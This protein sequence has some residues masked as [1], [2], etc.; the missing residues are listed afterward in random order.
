MRLVIVNDVSVVLGGAT[1]VA[2]QCIEAGIAAGMDCSVLVGD[3]GEGVR[4]R[5][6][7]AKVTSLGERPLR[8][9]VRLRDVIDRNYNRRAYEALDNMLAEGDEETVVHVHGWSQILSPSIFHALARHRARVIVTAHDFF[10]NCPNGGY[11]NF[12]TGDVCNY[13]PMST[14]C[15]C[16]NCDKRNYMH[17]LWRVGRMLTQRSAGQTFWNRVEVILAHENMEPY[18][19][20]A[21]LKHFRTLRT[22]CKPLTAE[23]VRA[24]QNDRTLFLGRMTWEKGVRTLAEALNRTGRTATLIGQGPLL[25]EMQDALPNCYVPGWLEDSEVQRIAAEARFFL[26][27][28]RMP[29]P[30]G[31]V[32]AEAMMSGIPVIVSSNALIAEE[33]ASNGAGLVFESGNAASL[34][35]KMAMMDSVVTVRRLSEGAYEYGKR[36]A[37]DGYEWSRRLTDIYQRSK[38]SVVEEA[39]VGSVPEKVQL[40]H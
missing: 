36:I 7:G 8:D 21:G 15:V 2:M 18:L 11:L 9:G 17:K 33:V 19:R 31:L 35:E 20:S 39:E 4:A 34:A 29:E 5:F 3:D 30:Y 16:S 28:S 37:P 10:L 32:A 25:K 1:K 24:W 27:P 38:P 40:I 6:P 26:M 12:R 22:P 13:Q 23:P 14:A